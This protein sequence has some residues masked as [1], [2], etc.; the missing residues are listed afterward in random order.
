MRKARAMRGKDRGCD[1]M[2]GTF[3]LV[4]TYRV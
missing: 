2:R 3:V 1:Q 4:P